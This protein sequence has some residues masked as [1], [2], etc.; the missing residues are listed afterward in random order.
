MTTCNTSRRNFLRAAGLGVGGL[1]ASGWLSALADE[2]ARDPDRRR[3]CILLWMTGGPSQ[4]DTLDPKPGQANGGEFKAIDTSVPGIQIGEHL[5]R[6]SRLMEHI[7]VIRSM[8]TK[9][10]DHARAMY[11]QRTGH[12]PQG[13][14]NYPTLG[15]LLSHRL[16]T[17]QSEL[18][19]FVSVTP[20]RPL[21]PRAFGPGFL[22][23]RHAPLIVGG[24]AA[25][26]QAAA[27]NNLQESLTVRNLERPSGVS[28]VENDAR[29]DLL[30]FLDEDFAAQ[31]RDAVSANHRAAYNAAVRMMRS[32]AISAFDLQEE[33]EATRN[34][35]GSTP[36]GQGCLLARRLVERGVPFIE[37]SLSGALG[38]NSFAWDTH[39]QN[40]PNVRRLCE[41]LDPAWSSLLEDLRERGLLETT[42]VVWMG[43]FG[44][45]PR[46]NGQAGRDHF[47]AA[48]SAALCGGGIR[49]G[50]V[51]GK[52]S[53]DGMRVTERPVSTIDFLDTICRALGVDP[54]KQNI[55]NV[56]RPIPLVDSEAQS[57]K[58]VL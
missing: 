33:S 4:I 13:P 3:A 22:G 49:G 36:F 31:H 24:S 41:T 47:P 27:R 32:S 50:Q 37:V 53:D 23:P 20:F 34:R 39:Q 42:Q 10:G 18:P 19:H 54:T 55:S 43:E 57:I 48:W 1:S 7:A 28:Q 15:S 40:F 17:D 46:I 56:G 38:N 6:V 35:Y 14:I 26:A 5:P 2:T 52:T 25:S 44:R 9:E 51:V 11:L 45:T 12:L 8:S 58:E 21:S 30:N 16:G 29:L